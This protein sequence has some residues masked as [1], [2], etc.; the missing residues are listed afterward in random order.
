MQ[1]HLVIHPDQSQA[2]PGHIH[3]II[4]S[5]SKDFILYK[6]FNTHYLSCCKR[7]VIDKDKFKQLADFFLFF[8]W[9]PWL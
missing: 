5:G 3:V 7:L 9:V 2:G 4:K 1:L 8:I 6:V